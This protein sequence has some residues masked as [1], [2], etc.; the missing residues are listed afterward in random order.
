MKIS[1]ADFKSKCLGLMDQVQKTHE[2]VVITKYGKPVARLVH[3]EESE[4]SPLFGFLKG[5]LI[6]K[7]NIVKTPDVKWDVEK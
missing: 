5:R 1:A 7:G 3:V 2:E 6:Q 4:E